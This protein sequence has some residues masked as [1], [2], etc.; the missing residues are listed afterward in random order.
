MLKIFNFA[1]KLL[2]T[3]FLFP[4]SHALTFQF[5]TLKSTTPQTFKNLAFK[6][7]K[8]VGG[9]R[10]KPSETPFKT[11]R[12]V[13]GDKVIVISGRDK[14]KQGIIY[15]VYRKQNSVSVSGINIL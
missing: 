2:P 10:K 14:G 3:P 11:W 15:R 9:S 5:H 4:A 1:R 6:T 7:M 13:K 12:L 8:N